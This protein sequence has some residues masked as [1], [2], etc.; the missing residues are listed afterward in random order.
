MTAIRTVLGD[1]PAAGLG[2]TDYHEHLFQVSPLL[3][4]EELDDEERSGAE[5]ASLR[6]CGVEAMVDATPQGLGR[7]PAA[8]AR[9]SER[10]GLRVVMTTGAHRFEHY[11]EG[12]WLTGLSAE[13]LG[14]RFLRDLLHG[15]PEADGPGEDLPAARGPGG[16]PVRAGVLKAGI[17]YWSIGPFERRVIEAV[18]AAHRRTGAPVMVH[19]EHGSAAFEVLAALDAEGV[20]AARVAL[21]HIDRNPDPGL[22]AELA[23]AGAYLGYD[24]PARHR[25]WPDSVLLDC[26]AEVAGRGGGDRLLLGGDVARRSRYRAYGGMPGLAYLGERFLP[27]L[28]ERTGAELEHAVLV[29]NPAAWL[30]WRV[31]EEVPGAQSAAK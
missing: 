8:V 28:R 10:T 19:L 20:P 11:G 7:D 12:H 6:A 2:R 30:T 1:L 3:P 14:E 25:E 27:R 9:I 24:G 4:G 15:A 17:G 21:A 22:H 23:A 5:A 31:P 13:A 29:A 16:E 26:L 18:G